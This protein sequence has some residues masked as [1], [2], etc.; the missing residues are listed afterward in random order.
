MSGSGE[1]RGWVTGPGYSTS[2][3]L[4]DRVS[5][6]QGLSFCPMNRLVALILLSAVTLS[7]HNGAVAIAVPVS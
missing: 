2:T 6:P 7:A 5:T 4:S 1:G 3:I